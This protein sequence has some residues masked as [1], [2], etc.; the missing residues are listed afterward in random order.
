MGS[1]SWRNLTNSNPLDRVLGRGGTVP[2]VAMTG[3]EWLLSLERDGVRVRAHPVELLLAEMILSSAF[4]SQAIPMERVQSNVPDDSLGKQ[5][6][7]PLRGRSR[8]VSRS[9]AGVEALTTDCYRS[10][11]RN[12]SDVITLSVESSL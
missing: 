7:L 11:D 6:G 9:R 5:I 4:T 1:T 12:V 3:G 8:S 2:A 10:G